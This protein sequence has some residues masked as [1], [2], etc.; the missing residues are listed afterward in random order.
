MEWVAVLVFVATWAFQLYWYYTL[1][2][3]WRNYHPSTSNTAKQPSVSI[4]VCAHNEINNLKILLPL[5]YQQQYPTYEIVVVEDTSYDGS[6]D[7]LLA[8]KEQHSNLKIVWLR[9]HPEH[10]GGKKYALTLGIRAARYPH[11]LLTDADCRPSSPFWVRSMIQSWAA[12]HE[13]VL[14]YSPYQTQPGLLN[15]FI[16]YETLHTG[17]MYLGAALKGY[18]YMGVGR[19]LAYRKLFFLE[20]GGFRG[21][22]HLTGGDDDIFVNRHATGRNTT[23]AIHV[24]SQMVSVP[25]TSWRAYIRQKI[26]HLS[27]G[28]YYKK[29][30]KRWLGVFSVTTIGFWL[31]CLFLL[32]TG[33]WMV[34]VL[35]L[36][37]R[38]GMMA[39]AFRST[40]NK[41]ND[42]IPLHMLPIFDFLYVIYY[43]SIGPIALLSKHIRWK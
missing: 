4:I 11:L 31:V 35:S 9:D 33:A 43:M 32:F 16:R 3:I 41:L 21:F 37:V 22:W 36:L 13:F 17:M 1:Y 15:G 39:L 24:E 10:V 7:F 23:I 40:A 5:L 20:S 14:G 38:W 6:L 30:D 18:P 26:R 2:S 27:V 28:K 42:S 19:N 25:K 12:E 34:A 8:Q 29:Q